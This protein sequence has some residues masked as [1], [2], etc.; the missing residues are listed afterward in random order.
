[1]ESSRG[2]HRGGRSSGGIVGQRFERLLVIGDV[3]KRDSSGSILWE[4]LCDCGNL[5]HIRSASL[6]RGEYR[7]C[8][9][10]TKDRMRET[11]PAQ[12]HGGSNTGT[13]RT[14]VVMKR[15]CTDEGFKDFPHY[16]GRGIKICS[17]WLKSFANFL[18][19]M[20]ERPEGMTLDRVDSE[21]DYCKGN[22]R[23]AT[24]LTQGNNTS[25]NHRITYEGRTRTL[26]EW[27]RITG[28]P[29]TR[30]RA[31]INILKWPTDR[32]LTEGKQNGKDH[33]NRKDSNTRIRV[34]PGVP[35]TP[36]LR[37]KRV[38]LP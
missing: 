10:W 28:I 22:C 5:R 33:Q 12:T 3:G 31:R 24:R 26:A 38:R 7:S 36:R 27:A 30:L 21:G 32:A 8:G 2:P 9:C 6:L 4:C 14:W 16:G 25:R 19:D 20:G 23:W 29:Y 17:S 1:M 11:P 18:A 15:R 13:Y 34:R 35:S 37:I